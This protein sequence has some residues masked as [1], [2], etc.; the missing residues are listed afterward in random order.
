MG[1]ENKIAESNLTDDH[2]ENRSDAI[3]LL[4]KKNQK[5]ET[6]AYVYKSR[7][8]MLFLFSLT[9]FLN[10]L[11]F[12]SMSPVVETI[13]PYYD[14]SAVQVEWLANM[15]MVVFIFI[16]LPSAYIMTRFGVRTVLTSAAGFAAVG[17]AIQYGGTSRNGFTLIVIGQLFATITYGNMLQIPGELSALWFP[18]HERSLSTSIGVFM[19]IFGLAIGFVQPS[20]MIPVTEDSSQIES[21]LKSFFLS[22]L[23][24]AVITFVLTVFLYR[25]KPP[26][27]PSVIEGKPQMGFFESLK[28]LFKDK[29]FMV[30][31]HAY[32]IYYG[33]FVAVSVLISRIVTWQFGADAN[34]QHFIG[35]MGFACDI[36]AIFSIFLIGLYL[37]RYPRHQGVAMFL[38][39]GSFWMWLIFIIILTETRNFTA[40]FVVYT[41]YGIV[42]IPYFAS[43]VEQA[44]EMTSPVPEGTSSTMIML[45]GNIYGFAFIFSI[46]VLIEDGFERT[47]VYIILGL[48]LVSFILVCIAKTKLKR[49]EAE[50]V[51]RSQF[52]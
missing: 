38:N 22:R 8:L 50:S 41:I 51:S 28:A 46:G 29:Y 35:W 47:A 45:L 48:Y 30:M 36:A 15:F 44:A 32:G 9:T 19:N 2:D 17:A 12:M 25:E 52:L 16:C 6:G 27:P 5:N 23:I 20:S 21:A 10:A 40:M 39:G 33:L 3:P 13:A 26:T 1:K 7:W 4:S 11:M 34:I 14:V 43:G 31:S 37:D 24:F 49:S 18:A 42:G